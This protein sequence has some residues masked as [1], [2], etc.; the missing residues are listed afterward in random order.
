MFKKTAIS[1]LMGAVALTGV[2][3]AEDLPK[4]GPEHLIHVHQPDGYR[5]MRL[6]YDLDGDGDVEITE[7][8]Y[9]YKGFVSKPFLIWYDRDNDGKLDNDEVIEPDYPKG[10]KT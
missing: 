9:W 2:A 7:S 5:I 6:C 3:L 8:R 10:E 1:G 4:Y